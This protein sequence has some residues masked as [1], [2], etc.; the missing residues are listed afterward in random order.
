MGPLD[1]LWMGFDGRDA[2]EVPQDPRPGGVVL[3]AK[4][5]DPDPEAGPR[6][7]HALVIDLR[8]RWAPLAVALDQ[9]GGPV[10][11]LKGW[12]GPTPPLRHVWRTGGVEACARW[13]ALWGRGLDLLGIQVDFAPVADLH[14]GHEGTGLKGRCASPYPGETAR[15]AGAFLWGLEGQGVQGCLK[16]FPGLGG[17]TVDSHRA[18]PALADPEVVA[19]NLRPFQ[20]LAQDSRLIMVA[21]VKTP[22]SEGRPASLHRGSVAENP[23][24]VR[25]IFIPDALEMG[26]CAAADWEDRLRQALEAGHVALLVCQ[27]NEA[28]RQAV[29]ALKSLPERLWLPAAEGFKV[30]RQRLDSP[31]TP[32]SDAAW[33]AWVEEVHT[34][35]RRTAPWEGVGV[36]PTV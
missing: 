33:K 22:H 26:G 31:M 10:S 7:C 23:W 2:A 18:L 4:N 24:G 29:E 3:F 21:H 8:A 9:E 17:T 14:D 34:E 15:A 27:P 5:L 25:G 6:R 12:V 35:V 13:G 30:L 32:W 1:T 36:D 16:H 19:R 28:V 11:R 20:A